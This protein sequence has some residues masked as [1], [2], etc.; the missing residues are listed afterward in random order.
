MGLPGSGKTT[1][2]EAMFHEFDKHKKSVFWYNADSVRNIYNDWDFSD[3]GRLRQ[4]Q[5]MHDLTNVNQDLDYVI[6]D[7]VCP[8]PLLRAIF[9]PDILIWVNTVMSSRYEDT[10]D[11]F[12]SPKH[13]DFQVV[14]KNAELF[15]RDIVEEILKKENING[16]V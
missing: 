11:K 9:K 3:T 16:S 7:F 4:A 14:G 10:N 8:T 5:R 15:A 2:A 12:T 13:W 6:C 1:L